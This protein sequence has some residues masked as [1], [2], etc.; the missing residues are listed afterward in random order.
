M[1]AQFKEKGIEFIKEAV[2]EDES[3]N[4]QKAIDKYFDGLKC[5]EMH[6]KYDKNEQTKQAIKA[7]FKEYLERAEY[8]KGLLKDGAVQETAAVTPEGSQQRPTPP[9]RKP[10]GNVDNEDEKNRMQEGL[11]SA[12]ITEKPDVKWDDVAGLENA[13]EALKEA[14]IMPVK[15]PQF[16]T[17]KRRPWSGILLYGP[18]GTGKSYLAKA[19]AT[20]A[21]STF[22]SVAASDL[23]SKWMGESEKLVSNLFE[24]ARKNSP[25]I[26]F[27]DEV[28]SLCSAR[29]DNES[30]A[31]RRIKTQFLIE[32]Q[33]V[34]DAKDSRVLVLGATNLPYIL[35][36]AVRR[37]FDKRIYIPLP[38]APARAGMFKI[39]LGT[40]PN[41]LNDADF[42]KLG[43]RTEGFSG[44]DISVVVKDVLM[45]PLRFIRQATH[46]RKIPGADGF[47]YV[48]CLPNT[49]GA[50]QMNLQY[51][52]E[53]DL[54][55][56]VEPPSISMTDFET[57]L[58]RAKP[59]VGK[60]D[61]AVFERFTEEFGEEG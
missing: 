40:T 41:L 19:V 9:G 49:P 4:Y 51:F 22:F 20:E 45:Q 47:R 42:E 1:Y 2:Q 46:F 52:A 28:D 54:G 16:F 6:L 48:P 36:Q 43:N 7:K 33:A 15:F 26:V 14:V 44:S 35:D 60:E 50:M 34:K 56:K 24:M 38:E 11:S 17:G 53:N 55:D 25:A 3:G 12:I 10:G 32:M 37:R 61:L 39:H 23:V 5:F 29:G 31:A 30:E 58:A 57:V 59:T 13:K 18:P 27:L 8:L 21:D